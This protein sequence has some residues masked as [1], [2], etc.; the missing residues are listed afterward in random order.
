V[1]TSAT[2]NNNFYTLIAIIYRM[3]NRTNRVKPGINQ[4]IQII[5]SAHTP[6]EEINSLQAILN[7]IKWFNDHG[8]KPTFPEYPELQIPFSDEEKDQKLNI[9]LSEYKPEFYD[10]GIK[11]LNKYVNEI[12]SVYPAFLKLNHLWKFKVFSQY[13]IAITKYGMGGSYSF[14][15]GKITMRLK[16]NG[17]FYL[18]Q[19]HHT[20]IHE[21]IHI[22]IEEVLVIK[23]KLTQPEKERLV[24]RMVLTL[25]A[26]LV[27]DY[28]F[29]R[30]GDPKIDSFVSP[31]TINNLPEAINHFIKY[32]P[33]KKI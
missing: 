16:E 9:L 28:E 15:T 31:E 12:K 8:Y 5:I 29:Q 25:F 26:D 1:N 6:L 17:T 33:R 30:I 24:D 4:K 13:L 20:V 11:L 2:E 3:I 10:V 19:P 23:Y 7:K 21:M 27:P 22:G 18:Q 32:Y 14:E